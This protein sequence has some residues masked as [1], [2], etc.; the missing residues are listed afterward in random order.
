MDRVEHAC[1]IVAVQ[2]R[3]FTQHDAATLLHPHRT[4]PRLLGSDADLEGAAAEDGNTT[5]DPCGTTTRGPAALEH[6]AFHSQRPIPHLQRPSKLGAAFMKCA[7][8]HIQSPAVHSVEG[9]RRGAGAQIE[10]GRVWRGGLQR[11]AS[12]ADEPDLAGLRSSIEDERG[13]VEQVRTRS[14]VDHHG[15]TGRG[16]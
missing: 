15:D 14:E 9:D 16:V 2:E 4:A 5:R 3:S 10:Q 1:G 12:G 11:R 6:R 8:L 7:I 13:A